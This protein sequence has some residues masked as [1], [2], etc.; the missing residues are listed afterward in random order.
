MKR[1]KHLNVCDVRTQGIVRDDVLIP[2]FTVSC[3]LVDCLPMGSDGS[4]PG[5]SFFCT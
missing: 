4:V 1:I 2:M 3:P 5:R